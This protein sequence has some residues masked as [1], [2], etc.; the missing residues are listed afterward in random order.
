MHRRWP[1][2]IWMLALTLVAG[3]AWAQ[4]VV[5]PA[6]Q[7]DVR[8]DARISP[9]EKSAHVKIVLG[10]GASLVR[11][12]RLRIDPQRHFDFTGDG[13]IQLGEGTVSWTPPATGGALSYRFQIDHLRDERSY[14]ARCTERWAI[15][16]GD[17]LV[18]AARVRVEAGAVSNSQLRLRVPEGWSIAVPYRKISGS[19]Y[20]I[21]HPH[22]SF[23][24]P[25]GWFA[26]GDIG[27]VRED[28]EGVKVSIA[29]PK[30]H[31]MHRL[32]L[33]AMLRW[34]L[35]DLKKAAGALP[36][37]LNVV[38][39]GDPMWRGGLSGPRSLYLHAD[40]A[41]ISEDGTSPLLH[42][43]VHTSLGI[44]AA[45]DSD[46]IIE[47]IAEH[48]SLEL[49][50][51]S[52]TVSKKRN[53]RVIEGQRKKA[54]RPRTTNGSEAVGPA[55]ARALLAIR[56]LDALIRQETAEAKSL[57]DVLKALVRQHGAVDR[58]QFQEI[59]ETATGLNLAA[60]FAKQATRQAQSASAN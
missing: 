51:R 56:E 46:W 4:D 59:A 41:L 10:K 2:P 34:T 13:E 14:D 7:Y 58:A 35:P 44:G 27:V 26:L 39:G 42:E 60:Y 38:G 6:R 8:Y 32:D 17:D 9:T 18:P 49:L 31:G 37:R 22:R 16:R 53:R 28:I 57:D 20:Q 1:I 54:Q 21:D 23:D 29:G 55:Q 5:T 47:G 52:G 25:T 33:L 19:L 43:L 3:G 40:R 50:V 45:A 11:Q 15:L 24:R 30:R 48:Y 12:I 36:P